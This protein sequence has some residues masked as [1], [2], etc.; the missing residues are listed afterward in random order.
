M[1]LRRC[2]FLKNTFKFIT[3]YYKNCVV[4]NIPEYYYIIIFIMKRSQ[5]CKGG[6]EGKHY[7][8]ED[9]N[10]TH[11]NPRTAEKETIME[12]IKYNV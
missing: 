8:T 6:R 11:P 12:D 10:P 7:Q 5:L 2:E 4:S 9:P 3:A 1:L